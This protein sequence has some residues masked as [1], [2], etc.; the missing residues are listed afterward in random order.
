MIFWPKSCQQWWCMSLSIKILR[1]CLSWSVETELVFS[2]LLQR[3]TSA[4]IPTFIWNSEAVCG[5]L[6]N[7][8]NL[9][10]S[11]QDLLWDLLLILVK[12]IFRDRIVLLV[13]IAEVLQGSSTHKDT[14][15]HWVNSKNNSFVDIWWSK[16][17]GTWFSITI[18][19][20]HNWMVNPAFLYL[21][22]Y[23]K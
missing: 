7:K 11:Q 3:Q 19:A 4:K 21:P 10:Y 2:Q 8:L 23:I 6:Q 14:E 9:Q 18:D 1:C 15:N 13:M 20:G 12:V 17:M 5:S 16:S 22:L